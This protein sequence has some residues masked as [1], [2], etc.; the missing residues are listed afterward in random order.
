M[1]TKLWAD[2]MSK[3]L[4]RFLKTETPKFRLH[5][6]LNE[7][8]NPRKNSIKA[9]YRPLVPLD[10]DNSVTFQRYTPECRHA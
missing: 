10:P 9:V 2:P 4:I 6:I 1:A 3:Y 8:I 7:S 5:P